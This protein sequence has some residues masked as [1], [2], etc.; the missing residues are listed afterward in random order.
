MKFNLYFFLAIIY[1][2]IFPGIGLSQVRCAASEIYDSQMKLDPEFRRKVESMEVITKEFSRKIEQANGE[3]IL[4]SVIRIPVVFHIL[5]NSENQYI[6]D[7]QI[8]SQLDVIN[9]DFNLK[10]T[11]IIS[12][13][14][15]DA[16]GSL[17]SNIQ[18][19]FCLAKRD[20]HGNPTDGTVKK[21]APKSTY[22][23]HLNDAMDINNGGVE[24]WDS[25]S[26]LNVIVVPYLVNNKN[27][28]LLGYATYPGT[29]ADKDGVVVAHHAFGTIGT[30]KHPFDK[31]RTLTHEIG[32]WLNLHHIWGKHN[33]KGILS[34]LDTDE[35][36][37]TPNQ[38][39]PNY[40]CPQFPS[41]SCSN[42]SKGGDMF[43]NYMDYV[44][45]ACMYMFTHG[46]KARM[47][48]I[49][50]PGGFR[51]SLLQSRGCEPP[52]NFPDLIVNSWSINPTSILA[53]NTT[54]VQFTIR[55]QGSTNAPSST[56]A[57]WLSKDN[58]FNG[59]PTD[60]NLNADV[61]VPAI[62]EG[63]TSAT[64]SKKVTIPSI[65][66]SGQWYIMLGADALSQVAESNEHN[67]QEF[68]PITV[69]SSCSI[70]K[71]SGI[72][73]G[74]LAS[75]GQTINTTT[76]TFNWN[77]VLGASAYIVRISRDPYGIANIIHTSPCTTPPYQ[78]P[79][80][81]L[82]AG[83][84]YRWDVEP[85]STCNSSCKGPISEDLYFNISS[86]CTTPTVQANGLFVG[87]VGSNALTL[88]W[89]SGNGARRVVKIN[90]TNSFTNMA[91]GADPVA[92]ANYSGSGE[93]VIY[94]G[95]GNSVIVTG[96][97]PNTS[98]CFRVYEVN[99]TGSST[100]YSNN[101]AINNP[102]C[103]NTISS[104]VAPSVQT[105]SITFS[106][107]SSNQ[108]TINWTNGNGSRR[109][110][111]ISPSVGISFPANGQD[112]TS[113]SFYTGG[114]QTVYNGAAN[115]VTVTRLNPSTTYYVRVFEA[116]CSGG[117]S[118][119][120]YNS[121]SGNPNN[122][123]TTAIGCTTPSPPSTPFE[124]SCP[125]FRVLNDFN[126]G[127]SFSYPIPWSS[128]TNATGYIFTFRKYPFNP[129]NTINLPGANCI[130]GQSYNVGP[131]LE[132]GMM[133][134]Y[135]IRATSQCGNA[136]CEG[137]PTSWRFLHTRPLIYPIPPPTANGVLYVCDQSGITLTTDVKAVT[138]PA[139]V[140]YLWY[141]DN[142][143]LSNGFLPSLFANVSGLY[144]LRVAYEGGALCNASDTT[145]AFF[146]RVNLGTTP[147]PPAPITGTS[148]LCVGEFLE[149]STPFETG[150][151][152][153]WEGPNGFKSDFRNAIAF[154]SSSL[155]NTGTYSCYRIK[156]GCKSGPIYKD[157]KV[158]QVPVSGFTNVVNEN[159]VTFTNTSSNSDGY[160]WHFGDGVESQQK[161]PTYSYN[162]TGSFSVCLTSTSLGCTPSSFCK[163]ITIGSPPFPFV[164]T[165]P[166]F[167]R[168]ISDT[169]QNHKF[170][171][172]YESAI[173]NSD[174]G[175]LVATAF[176]N[177]QTNLN[178][179][180]Q[181]IR[182]DKNGR[183]IWTRQYQPTT[184]NY[185][186]IFNIE[187]DFLVAFPNNDGVTFHKIDVSGNTKLSKA[188]MGIS[189][190]PIFVLKNGEFI[191]VDP[192]NTGFG[193]SK[194][195]KNFNSI[196]H[197]SFTYNIFNSTSFFIRKVMVDNFGEIYVVGS[198]M[199]SAINP[200]L[201][202]ENAFI[203]KAD[204]IGNHLWTRSYNSNF[205]LRDLAN[206]ITTNE[207][208]NLFISGFSQSQTNGPLNGFIFKMNRSG[209]LLQA[210]SY[211]ASPMSN[212]LWSRTSTIVGYRWNKN[213]KPELFELDQNLN[214]LKR[215][216]I[217][218]TDGYYGEL[219]MTLD[220]QYFNAGQFSSIDAQ[221]EYKYVA[222]FDKISFAEADCRDTLL[223]SVAESNLTATLINL[224][225]NVQTFSV[226]ISDIPLNTF[227]VNSLN[228]P[229]C[230][231]SN[232]FITV[233]SG[234]W[235]DPRS[236]LEN[237][238]PG[239]ND[240]ATIRAGHSI[241]LRNS[242]KVNR[243]FIERLGSLSISDSKDSLTVGFNNNRRSTFS[244][245]GV[246]NIDNGV[247]TLNGCFHLG[248]GSTFNFLNGKF[249]IN[250][251]TGTQST[252]V[253]NGTHLFNAAPKMAMFNFS[254]GTLQIINPPL[255]SNSQAINSPYSFGS[256]S[257]LH[258]G[259]GSSTVSSNQ[260]N[261]F[262]GN[263]LP[264]EIG[265]LVMD[266]R[267]LT[268]NRHFK[269]VNLL[270]IT[271]GVELKSGRIVQSGA[272]V[273]K[274][275]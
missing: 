60:I 133:Y 243:L 27:E 155:S 176:Q 94:N 115:S 63:Q 88:F 128:S 241:L 126:Y 224:T 79:A 100:L 199:N 195:D 169:N 172:A 202:S 54:T 57:I 4:S 64:L 34:C 161:N 165:T 244:S 162:N 197:K 97:S 117:L 257:I 62:A 154:S 239:E 140:K 71:P 66:S 101:T 203:F 194:F 24:L 245:F 38:A 272:I 177:P 175:F 141:R 131:Y 237:L 187:N 264:F 107:V 83:V 12:V 234:L 171:N 220:G 49:F 30:A 204:A 139:R 46:Q 180:K 258:F 254:G 32:H 147:T 51:N 200:P 134:T 25:R 13:S 214:L 261:G 266:A 19:E 185:V 153:H 103:S 42:E 145:D 9:K 223:P 106:G 84:K 59:A 3:S 242:W 15:L 186:Q 190:G 255:G 116:N 87:N 44:D 23:S 14:V 90:R 10:N 263:L 210:K 113:S 41:P 232:S 163:E 125:G 95:S 114:E 55:N 6:N 110:V 252:S 81:I 233:N 173:V 11:D 127:P 256:H 80:G 130:S 20:I 206:S 262:G 70:N 105:R 151:S 160:V 274:N 124:T 136:N 218:K 123:L 193:I 269:N 150:F 92:N 47:R 144:S 143:L 43:M 249:I 250:G 240:S 157:V 159:L 246:L 248:S 8:Q 7:D 156:D 73:P 217:L 181:I 26:Y 215:K 40:Y 16:F 221:G 212:L 58:I 52:D 67:N 275:E 21:F 77:T 102:F 253:P 109:I 65:T 85:F 179:F 48:A 184:S 129:E 104:C 227:I 93:Q 2:F 222:S 259:N 168:F 119:Y 229:K 96:L 149:L 75:S 216:G 267:V 208:G 207:I 170:W 236:W 152:Y 219:K 28:S 164:Q 120:N 142:V 98:Y 198:Y 174:S 82:Q 251:N 45:D 72:S 137:M 122:Q 22:S 228:I 50:Q 91:N 138:S 121:E 33:Y 260:V 132:P 39:R 112:Y 270:I 271:G 178:S 37:D 213:E 56:T 17:R 5:Y 235:S 189:L 118:V 183:T 201:D 89:N 192:K 211:A 69:S 76:P 146:V 108:F 53:G 238:V 99:C 247:I 268:N 31:G 148:E 18:I 205:N 135:N 167:G 158:K 182:L 68:L 74:V 188:I 273:V 35:V 1:S 86:S 225:P 29:R 61:S 36:D 191:V 166:S 230:N 231:P 226:G 265:K 196:W 209:N 111:R 78:I